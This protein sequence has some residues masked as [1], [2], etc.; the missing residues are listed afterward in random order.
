[1][2]GETDEMEW[3]PMRG[4]SVRVN[5]GGK[6]AEWPFEEVAA[7]QMVWTSR[8]KSAGRV[9]HAM[10]VTGRV[11]SV[12]PKNPLVP[13]EVADRTVV[14]TREWSRDRPGARRRGEKA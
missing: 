7:V 6:I 8:V 11:Q 2:A 10:T 5:R 1:M 13:T 9:V 14:T 12:N 4:M 3:V